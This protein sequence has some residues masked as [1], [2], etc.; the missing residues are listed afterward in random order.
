MAG[1]AIYM[2]VDVAKTFLDVADDDSG[3]VR[4]F[5]NDEEGI[6]SAVDFI[7]SLGPQGIILEATGNLE[8][9]LAA[10]LQAASLP[11]SVI[12]PRKVRD[13]ARATRVLA[14]TDA[15]DARVLALFGSRVK[16]EVRILPN[17]ESCEMSSLLRHRLQLVKMLTSERNRVLQSDK[18]VRPEIAA[19]IEWLKKALSEMDTDI[20]NRIKCSPSWLEKDNLLSDLP[21]NYTQLA[22]KWWTLT[23][24]NISQKSV[25]LQLTYK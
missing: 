17:K 16:P 19:H 9:P 8:M 3:S 1:K 11:V 25:M 15:I 18:D 13:F 6:Q 5:A 4:R 21:E 20:E 23:S 14:K 24:L 22:V 7:G 10:A 2:G 12:N